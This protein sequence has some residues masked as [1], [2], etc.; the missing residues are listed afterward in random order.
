VR[1]STLGRLLPFQSD[2]LSRWADAL[3]SAGLPD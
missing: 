1:L 2:D 3:R